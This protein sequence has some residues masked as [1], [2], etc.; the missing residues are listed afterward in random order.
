MRRV[1]AWLVSLECCDALVID[2]FFDLVRIEPHEFADLAEWDAAFGDEPTHE[3]LGDAELRRKSS[4]VQE[5]NR[6][7]VPLTLR[8]GLAPPIGA[9]TPLLVG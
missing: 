7:F 5:M 6:T 2:P 1:P 8:C 4:N 9:S 3:S